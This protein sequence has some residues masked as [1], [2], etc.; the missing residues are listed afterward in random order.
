MN[1]SGQG[2]FVDCCPQPAGP[3]RL[4]TEQE[5]V[6]GSGWDKLRNDELSLA[7]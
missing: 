5:M 4:P 1:N 6:A 3:K 2:V 7:L